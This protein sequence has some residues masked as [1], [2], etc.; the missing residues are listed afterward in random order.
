MW[1]YAKIWLNIFENVHLS[2]PDIYAPPIPLYR[3]LNTP[4]LLSCWKNSNGRIFA[5]CQ[6]H[7]ACKNYT[8]RTGI[9]TGWTSTRQYSW[10]TYPGRHGDHWNIVT[11]CVQ[12]YH[13]HGCRQYQNAKD[14]DEREVN[15]WKFN[16]ENIDKCHTPNNNRKDDGRERRH[17]DSNLD[18]IQ[19]CCCAFLQRNRMLVEAF[20]KILYK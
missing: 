13:T 1:K 5:M 11:A 14:Y 3:F 9:S 20:V 10:E 4:L 8:L 15:H 19:D 16:Q 7:K 2:T 17:D 12:G 18:A 6:Q